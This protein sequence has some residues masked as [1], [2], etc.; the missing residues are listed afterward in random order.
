MEAD[1]NIEPGVGEKS[2]VKLLTLH[3][4]RLHIK[5]LISGLNVHRSLHSPLRINAMDVHTGGPLESDHSLPR[6]AARNLSD[7]V[8]NSATRA[9]LKNLRLRVPRYL[10]RGVRISIGK[11]VPD[12]ASLVRGVLHRTEPPFATHFLSQKYANH[13]VPYF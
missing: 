4:R 3:N 10:F 8:M 11:R 1:N 13:L 6:V 5:M 2:K 7:T 9:K 12:S